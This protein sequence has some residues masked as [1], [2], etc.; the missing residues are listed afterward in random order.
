M[1][2]FCSSCSSSFR[3]AGAADELDAGGST[4][5]K[6]EAERKEEEEE[7]EEDGGDED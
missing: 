5:E 1:S 2:A 6:E 7:K 3:F 4:V